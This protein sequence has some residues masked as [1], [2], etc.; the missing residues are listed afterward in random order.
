MSYSIADRV[1]EPI[2]Q[3][4]SLGWMDG[5]LLGQLGSIDPRP[6]GFANRGW[7]PIGVYE[8]SISGQTSSRDEGLTRTTGPGNHRG[9]GTVVQGSNSR[10]RDGPRQICF[11][12]F[13][14]RKDGGQRPVVNLKGLNQFV[15]VEHFKMEGLHLLPDLIQAG[16]GW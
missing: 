1:H 10:D 2:N 12:N 5:T 16:A 14:G 9:C 8:S 4:S 7:L 3:I 13:P 6:M 15:K 11:P